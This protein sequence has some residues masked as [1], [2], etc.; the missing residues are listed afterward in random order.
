[1]VDQY[2]KAWRG[3]HTGAPGARD[4]L[5]AQTSLRCLHSSIAFGRVLM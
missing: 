5:R 2:V 4:G 3:D 1:M